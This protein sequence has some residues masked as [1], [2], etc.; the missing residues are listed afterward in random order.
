TKR[1]PKPC[2]PPPLQPFAPISAWKPAL[3]NSPERLSR[4]ASLPQ[5]QLPQPTTRNSCRPASHPSVFFSS[6]LLTTPPLHTQPPNLSSTDLLPCLK[7][8]ARPRRRPS[9]R[10]LRKARR[11][12]TLSSAPTARPSEHSAPP[13]PQP[14][15]PVTLT[16][17]ICVGP[18]LTLHL[19][20]PL[21]HPTPLPEPPSVSQ[22]SL[23][24]HCLAI[25]P[26]RSQ[27]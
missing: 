5:N 21:L 27:V 18:R 23:A 6:C 26:I 24:G 16:T 4:T 13:M 10:R 12:L 20:W 15:S 19:Q 9:A 2:R 3:E 8:L 1:S 14:P 17:T 7:L 11:L 22:H 25:L